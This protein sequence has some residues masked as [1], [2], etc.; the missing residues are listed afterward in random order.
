MLIFNC[1]KAAT[2]FF[3]VTR[4]GK[5]ISCMEPAPHKTIAESVTSP[6][7]PENVDPEE[8][9][10]FQWQWVIHCVSIK[11]KKYLMVVDYQTRFCITLLAGKKGDEYAFLNMFDSM[12]KA[13]FQQLAI[14]QGLDEV[15]I[16]Q[17][18]DDYDHKIFTCAFH[19]R[20]DRSVQ[21]HINDMAWHL[22]S[23]C[24]K[25]GMIMDDIDLI[26]FNLFTGQFPRNAKDRKD[27]FFPYQEFIKVWQ[28]PSQ[29]H[30]NLSNKVILLSQYQQ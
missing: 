16:A 14:D 20:S 15:E 11:R 19:A 3:T 26:N 25:E 10:G 22:E 13:T 21:G 17:C 24:Y 9:A 5:K 8:N 2:E 29:R 30:T 18:I 12:L 27:H 4:Q 28:Q 6:I 23:Q 1:T 7:F